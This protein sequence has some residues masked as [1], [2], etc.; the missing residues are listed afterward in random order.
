M[1]SYD[2]SILNFIFFRLS[3]P[4]KQ[5][6]PKQYTRIPCKPRVKK[7]IFYLNF[8]PLKNVNRKTIKPRKNE[9][10]IREKQMILWPQL[11]CSIFNCLTTLIR[12]VEKSWG[13]RGDF[14]MAPKSSIKVLYIF[15]LPAGP[16]GFKLVASRLMI[17]GV[18]IFIPRSCPQWAVT[19]HTNN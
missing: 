13:R 6:S 3:H 1:E 5:V 15:L 16:W 10:K 8:P 17:I 9:K 14:L 2:F 12:P 19:R 18:N 4:S 11:K 7:V